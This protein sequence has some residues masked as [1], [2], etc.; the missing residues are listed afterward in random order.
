MHLRALVAVVVCLCALLV[1]G[2]ADASNPQIAGLQVALR[3]WGYYHGSVDGVSGPQTT[4]AIRSFQRHAGLHVDGIAGPQTRHALGR[5]GRPL[6][7]KR[8]LRRGMHGWDVAV[9]QFMLVRRGVSPGIVDGY[10]GP[11]T[12]HA[13]RRF[14]R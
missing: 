12:N 13:V 4:H 11:E 5:V 9:L 2:P 7:G 1:A 8:A 14:Q 3:S 6:Y 10:F